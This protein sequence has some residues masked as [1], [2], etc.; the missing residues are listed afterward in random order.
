MIRCG[1]DVLMQDPQWHRHA[2]H[3]GRV[4]LVTHASTVAGDGQDAVTALDKVLRKNVSGSELVAVMGPQHGFWQCEPYNMIETPDGELKLRG[5]RVLPLFS[6]Y[7]EHREPSLRHLEQFD[8]MVVDLPDIGCRIYTYMTTLAGCLRAAARTGKRVVVLDRPNPLG[9]SDKGGSRVE[10]NIVLPHLSSFVGWYAIPMRHG[11]TLGELGHWF[12]GQEGLS[13]TMAGLYDVVTVQGLNRSMGLRDLGQSL[14][15]MASPNMPGPW[16]M[17]FFPVS[18]ALEGCNISEGRGTTAP[19]QSIG[20]PFLDEHKLCEALADAAARLGCSQDVTFRPHRFK[21]SFDKF[22]GEVC[23]GVFLQSP[24][25]VPQ[26]SFEWS[27]ALLSA[28]VRSAGQH[29]AWREP[30][31][32]YNFEAPPIDLILG[33]ERWRVA[34]DHLSQA[35]SDAAWSP[36]L[37]LLDEARRQARDFTLESASVVLYG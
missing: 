26:A 3:W 12:L 13:Q 29:F 15:L 5:G 17:G 8:T 20:A 14:P 37:A 6:L 7:G 4:A 9:L 24:C 32:E 33:D 1:L 28:L 11:L 25:G 21:P 19:F 36:L 35:S 30:G 10:G 27:I 22:S 16:T 18:V 34:L 31:Y 2:G 23:R